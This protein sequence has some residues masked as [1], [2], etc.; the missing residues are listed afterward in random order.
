L[1]VPGCGAAI[2]FIFRQRRAIKNK[3]PIKQTARGES[4]VFHWSYIILPAVILL[5]SVILIVYFYHQLPL[6][7]AYHFK[8]DGSPD[9]WLSRG[10]IILWAL[11]PQLFF[12]LMAGTI[13]WGIT[14][15]AALSRQPESSWV[16]PERVLL[17]MGNMIALPQIVLCFAMLDI[18]SYNSYQIHLM[19]V[20]VFA[21]IVMGLGAIILGVFFIQAIQQ[22]WRAA[23]QRPQ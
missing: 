1:L 19:P 21:L 5:L 22:A 15:L 14:K 4:L 16:K 13:T 18:F 9:K 6:E 2:W 11:L 17:F 12:T 8:S 7:V 23:Q 20:W 10:M 3:E